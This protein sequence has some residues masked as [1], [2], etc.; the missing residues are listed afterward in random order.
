MSICPEAEYRA[1]L[2]DGEFWERVFH[3]DDGPDDILDDPYIF[4]A[5]LDVVL[6]TPCE[7]CGMLGPCSYDS[8]GEPY[9]HATP[10]DHEVESLDRL[11]AA[12]R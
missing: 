10:P 6:L 5:P 3:G 2:S 7:L 9:F 1:S 11:Y 12:L 8:E 4:E